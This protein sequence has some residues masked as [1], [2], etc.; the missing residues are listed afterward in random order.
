MKSLNH[1]I[2]NNCCKHDTE[3]KTGLS[4]GYFTKVS[5]PEC[6]TTS[7]TSDSAL[8]DEEALEQIEIS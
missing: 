3:K 5:G 2:N 4:F 8:F 1:N 7:P 6:P